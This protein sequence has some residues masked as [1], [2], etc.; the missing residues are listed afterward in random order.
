MFYSGDRGNGELSGDIGFG[1]Y[2]DKQSIEK[3]KIRAMAM[4]RTSHRLSIRKITLSGFVVDAD[5]FIQWFDPQKLRCINFKG[6]CID[7]GFWLPL[8][9]KVT[10]RFPRNIDHQ[11]VPV[12]ILKIDVKRDLSVV[13]LEGGKKVKETSYQEFMGEGHCAD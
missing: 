9:M 2:L 10:V 3:A 5:P 1:E 6:R 8:S 13:E 12:G 4:G 7:A 11:P